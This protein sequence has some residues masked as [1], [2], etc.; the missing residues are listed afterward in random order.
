VVPKLLAGLL[1]AG[2]PIPWPTRIVKGA[3]DLLVDR[4]W[5]IALVVVAA[6]TGLGALLRSPRGRLGWHALQL[7]IPL[8]GE[9]IRKQAVSRIAIVVS[10]LMRSGIV[11]L[12]A[13]QIAQ[14]TTPNLVL[15]RALERCETA[16]HA[17]R[18]IAGALERTHAFPPTVIQVFAVG[19]QSGRLEEMLDRLAT[20]YDH[21][22]AAISQRLVA[23]LEPLLIIFMVLL[24]GLIAFATVLPMLE[25]G[26]VL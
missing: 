9:I 14:R 19:E 23:V 26:R 21:Q 20:D 17:G 2:R 1:E 3:S 10:T 13:V 18:D 4:W 11:F 12:K 6:A 8:L 16:V 24:V 25:A 22:V 7:R 15:R 5:L